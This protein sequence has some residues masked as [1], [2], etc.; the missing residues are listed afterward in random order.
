LT[1]LARGL[2]L[3]LSDVF[4]KNM[5]CKTILSI[6]TDIACSKRVCNGTGFF[7]I[8]FYEKERFFDNALFVLISFRF[9]ETLTTLGLKIFK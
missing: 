8:I 5:F 7:S 6:M 4:C 3:G 1:T 2:W 9:H